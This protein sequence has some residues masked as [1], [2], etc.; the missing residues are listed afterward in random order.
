MHC[1]VTPL[2]REEITREKALATVVQGQGAE[3]LLD[4][5][6][7]DEPAAA[8]PAPTG[9]GGLD[10]LMMSDDAAPVATSPAAAS[11]AASAQQ[12]QQGS[13]NDLL[14]LFDAAPPTS[15]TGN[16]SALDFL[17]N[18]P[19]A[20]TAP[21]VRNHVPAQQQGGDLLDLI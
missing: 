2:R 19:S 12:Q 14:G 18:M 9:L 21:P 20:P 6:V 10:D 8:A 4:F 16:T 13:L 7:D 17:N 5:D 3:N 15:G 1:T 11:S